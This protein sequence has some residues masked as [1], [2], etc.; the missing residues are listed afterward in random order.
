VSKCTSTTFTMADMLVAM[1]YDEDLAKRAIAQTGGDVQVSVDV[2]SLI[3]SI[4]CVPRRVRAPCD[5]A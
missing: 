1:G 5:C 3:E 2:P 4:E